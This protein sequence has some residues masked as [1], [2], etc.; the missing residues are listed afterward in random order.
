MG[1]GKWSVKYL[2]QGY[3]NGQSFL[4]KL[5]IGVVQSLQY[6]NQRYA[7]GSN[8][9]GRMVSITRSLGRGRHHTPS[10]QLLENHPQH[11]LY[12]RTALN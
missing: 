7:H 5:E 12:R 2:C 8:D 11:S 6:R 10:L 3:R 1:A 9:I 4:V